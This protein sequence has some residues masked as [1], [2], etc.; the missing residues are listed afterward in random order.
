MVGP[1]GEH[2]AARSSLRHQPGIGIGIRASGRSSLRWDRQTVE[3]EEDEKEEVSAPESTLPIII[4]N[5][6]AHHPNRHY[7]SSLWKQQLPQ[8]D[9]NQA[10]AGPGTTVGQT[11]Q[12]CRY[13]YLAAQAAPEI[14]YTTTTTRTTNNN[15]QSLFFGWVPCPGSHSLF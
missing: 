8:A 6:L 13:R 11:T 10:A 15:V 9:W 4:T 7:R 12:V 1:S 2:Q 14:C 3:E 5:S